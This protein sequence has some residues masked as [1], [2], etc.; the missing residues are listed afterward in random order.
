LIS[1]PPGSVAPVEKPERKARWIARPRLT[2]WGRH[3]AG[4]QPAKATAARRSLIDRCE[5][6][7]GQPFLI[8]R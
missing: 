5:K 8:L 3:E 4:S 6:P 2:H 7:P 1:V